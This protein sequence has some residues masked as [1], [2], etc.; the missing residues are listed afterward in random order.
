MRARAYR[1]IAATL[2]DSII[3]DPEMRVLT[4]VDLEI[5]SNSSRHR[6]R[7]ALC[8]YLSLALLG[9]SFGSESQPSVDENVP[10]LFVLQLSIRCL[11]EWDITCTLA[12]PQCIFARTSP[13]LP[14]IGNT[15]QQRTWKL[16]VCDFS[17]TNPI[18][19]LI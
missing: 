9:N 11:L 18:L 6:P 17:P 4:G 3:T 19:P 7:G 12:L 5:A 15:N 16:C 10:V 8:S 1:W 14:V 2:C 13:P